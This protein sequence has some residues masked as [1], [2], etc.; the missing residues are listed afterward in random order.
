MVCEVTI[1]IGFWLVIVPFMKPDQSTID[2]M[3][4]WMRVQTVMEHSM[5]MLA[6]AT[7]SLLNSQVMTKRGM[8]IVVLIV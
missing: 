3:T 2:N 4:F 6:L 1:S 7:D 5:P 8:I